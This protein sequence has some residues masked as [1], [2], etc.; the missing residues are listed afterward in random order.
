[1]PLERAVAMLTSQPAD[2]FGI[3]GRGRL[4]AG[5]AADVVVFDPDTV[6]ALPL[7]RVRDLPGGAE[8]LIA[9][10]RGIDH[11]F[12]NGEPIQSIQFEPTRARPGRLLRH[13]RA[14]N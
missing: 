9:K 4:A 2:L 12:V 8:R 6:G 5:A 14:T 13:G 10:A 1:L 3:E 7:E 11:V